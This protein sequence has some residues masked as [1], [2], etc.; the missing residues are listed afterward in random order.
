MASIVF[1]I[2][3]AAF[4][5]RA[6][7]LASK[8]RPAAAIR[9]SPAGVPKS[10]EDDDDARPIGYERHLYVDD[11]ARPIGY[12]TRLYVDDNALKSD[13]A[14]WAFY[15][16][17]CKH[18]GI[19]RERHEMERRFKKFSERARAV[20]SAGG[21]SGPMSLNIFADMTKEEAALLIGKPRVKGISPVHWSES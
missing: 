14:M 2:A 6:F 16:H 3:R 7:P 13:E 19:S 8:G 11:N 9:V 10:E 5:T 17:W 21:A 15:E 12:K 20:H 1:K 4:S 18:H